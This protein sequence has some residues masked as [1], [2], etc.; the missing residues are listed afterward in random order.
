MYEHTGKKLPIFYLKN[1]IHGKPARSYLV[2][3]WSYPDNYAPISL[4]PRH[5]VG[6][7]LPLGSEVNGKERRTVAQTD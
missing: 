1:M 5:I 4:V 6:K 7:S 2:K 3:G